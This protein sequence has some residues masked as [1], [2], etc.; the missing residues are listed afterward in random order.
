MN[1]L[2]YFLNK[3]DCSGYDD[4][5]KNCRIRV[6]HDFNFGFDVVDV[7]GT[8]APGQRALVWCNA[9]GYSR[10]MGFG[11]LADLSRRAAN[12][13][14]GLGIKKGDCVLLLL[15]RR[16]QYWYLVPAL[17]KIGAVVI[18]L[19]A[20]LR[21]KDLEYRCKVS[22]A[23][24]LI[25]VDDHEV[26]EMVESAL[27]NV[28]VPRVAHVAGVPLGAVDGDGNPAAESVTRAAARAG[29]IDADAGMAEADNSFARPTG[30]E[31]TKATDLMMCYFTSGTTGMPKMVAH[32]F[33]YPLG[34]VM[35][36]HY[37]QGSVD[38]GLQLLISDTAWCATS[39][40]AIYGQW[41]AGC[42]VMVYDF[43]V[44]H[45]KEIVDVVKR[46]RV[47]SVGAIPTFYRRI[48]K[49]CLHADD[50]AHVTH[51]STGAGPSSPELYHRFKQATGLELRELF[52]QTETSILFAA[53]PWLAARPGSIGKPSAGYDVDVIDEAGRSC[54]PGEEGE[55]V[56]RRK[57]LM[58]V[59]LFQ[60]YIN[61][62]ASTAASCRDGLYHTGDIIRRDADG[63]YWFIGRKDDLIKSSGY[64][65]SPVEVENVVLGHPA[66]FEVAVTGV[67][68]VE[69]GSVPKATIVLHREYADTDDLRKDIQAYVKNETAPYKYPRIIEFVET[70]PKTISGKIRH[71]AI[72]EQN[73]ET[74]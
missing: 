63:Y 68:D 32:N 38:G 74:G 56:V 21:A 26:A 13:L 10:E 59:G 33:A 52:G 35:A 39:Y 22:N 65:I 19:P 42:A 28:S 17:H 55:L 62:P 7:L 44:F 6:P 45:P 11:E 49:E 47:T 24:M 40:C 53:W 31:A 36:A 23:R 27:K 15:K 58:P 60:E 5:L 20:Q 41:I 66:V 61:D 8:E 14:K 18:P 64:R 43:D 12:W 16:C 9:N 1:L 50:W 2:H 46:Y 73:K 34:H 71:G 48:V 25:A 51:V 69:R 54:G 30:S 57:G 3:T 70:L 72:R 37:F 67:P 29:W 4:F